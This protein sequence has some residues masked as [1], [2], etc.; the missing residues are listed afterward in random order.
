[1]LMALLFWPSTV[2]ADQE[3][4]RSAE[5]S[6][7]AVKDNTAQNLSKKKLAI[8]TVLK[9]YNSPLL[10]SVDSF[11]STCVTY[12]LDCYLLPSITGLESTFGRFVPT[13]SS[14]PFGWGGGL[15][16][17]KNWEDA[18]NEVG[19]GLRQNYI[20]KGAETVDQIAPIYAESKTWAP[21]V[22]YFMEQFQQEEEKINLYL[23]PNKVNL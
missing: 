3:A 9:K 19:K 4:G 20:D 11:M 6:I 7:I 15:S 5:I 16:T 14:N 13:N 8:A 18:I 23:D 22:N 21:R 2:K 17:F 10:Q 1:M 12:N